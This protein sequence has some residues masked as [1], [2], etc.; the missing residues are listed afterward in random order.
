M[1]RDR[2]GGPL[3]VGPR[4]LS[5]ADDS[6]NELQFLI[7]RQ[8][9]TQRL[10]EVSKRHDLLHRRSEGHRFSWRDYPEFVS[11]TMDLNTRI[12]SHDDQVKNAK[13]GGGPLIKKDWRLFE[14]ILLQ[15]ATLTTNPNRNCRFCG[16]VLNRA[17]MPGMPA[18]Y[19]L[20]PS[21]R[22]PN[23]HVGQNGGQTD[24]CVPACSPAS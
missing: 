21:W 17:A 24:Y 2:P 1:D 7:D 16:C 3:K 11:T 22:V 18:Y 14:L 23:K 5:P 15:K 13:P 19:F 10:T 20:S 12:V 8:V 9:L 4:S 6:I